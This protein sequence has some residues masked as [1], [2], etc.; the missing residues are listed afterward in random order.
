M[1][2]ECFFCKIGKGM[3]EEPF[4][5]NEYFYARFDRY[6]IS[7]GHAE[8][9]PKRHAVSLFDLTEP[10]WSLLKP[11]LE[12]TVRIIESTDL[13][14]FYEELIRNPA[15]EKSVWHCQQMLKK[16]FFGKKPDGYNFGSNDG[17]A[18]GRTIHHLHIHVIPRYFGDV[19]DPRGGIRYIIPEYANYKK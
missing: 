15:N 1:D 2:D 4:Y 19:P 9:I 3:I 12:E 16:P 10:E 13:Q 6:P 8:V 5:D 18:A 17:P 7:P 14:K 11:T